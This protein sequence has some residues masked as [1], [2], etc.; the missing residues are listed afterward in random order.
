MAGVIL[1]DTSSQPK[2]RACPKCGKRN[3]TG[4]NIQGTVLWTC[5][6]SGCGNKWQGGMGKYGPQRDEGKPKPPEPPSV[7][8]NLEKR[9]EDGTLEELRPKQDPR[10]D[11]RTGAPIPD[12]GEEL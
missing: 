2:G 1:P 8:T 10:P 5:K 12:E 3:F 6:E 7:Y 4:Q 9:N 11:F